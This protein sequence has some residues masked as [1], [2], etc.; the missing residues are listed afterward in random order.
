MYQEI[1]KIN[2]ENELTF[3]YFKKIKLKTSHNTLKRRNELKLEENFVT[4]HEYSK[5][6]Y[7]SY[8]PWRLFI[9]IS[10]LKAKMRIVVNIRFP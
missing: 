9:H 4:Q 7:F 8:E 5:N 1:P 10:P 3:F 2:L 6:R